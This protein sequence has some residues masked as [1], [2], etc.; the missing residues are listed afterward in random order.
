MAE[1]TRKNNK[2]KGILGG[3]ILLLIILFAAY[4]YY[5]F[6]IAKSTKASYVKELSK[7]ADNANISE[8]DISGFPGKMIIRKDVERLSSDKGT[9]EILNLQAVS[10]PFTNMPI[11]IQTGE[12]RL[13]SSQWL[14][15]LSF[16]S[17]D[18]TIRASS[19]RVLFEDSAL[20]QRDFQAEVTGSVDISDSDVAIPDLVVSLSNHQD[21]LAVLVD[22]GIIEEQAAAF[23]GFGLSALTNSETGKIEVPIYARNGTINL[24]PLPILKLPRDEGYQAGDTPPRRVKPVVVDQ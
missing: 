24:G 22:S 4:S 16:D 18:A 20:K 23:V 19:T 15:G 5:W 12:I 13:R 9:L 2:S 10:W 3:I 7:L 8:P 1:A 11:D 17:F 6:E 21:F 14:E